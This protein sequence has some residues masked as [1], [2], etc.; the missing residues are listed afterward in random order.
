MLIFFFIIIIL[1][2]LSA[3]FSGSETAFFA[4]SKETHTK[5]RDK[6]AQ[7]TKS[8]KLITRLNLIESLLSNPSSLLATILF[9][10]LVVNT[11]AS[12]VFTLLMITLAEKFNLSRDLLVSLGA[13]ILTIILVTFCEITPKVIA[14]RKPGRFALRTAWFISV[15][16]KIFWFITTPL[17][18]ISDWMLKKISAYV[19][20]APFPSV[21]DLKTIIDVSEDQGLITPEEEDFLFNLVD[22]SNRRVA[23]IM[24]PRIKMICLE[25]EATITDAFSLINK[26]TLPLY[27]R[28]PVYKNSIDNITGV[29]YLKDLVIQKGF[30]SRSSKFLSQPVKDIVRP[31]YF[32]P[33][34]KSLSSLLEE[35]RKKDSHI[36]IVIDEYGQTAGLVTL[37]DILETLLGEIQDEYDTS[38]EM[39]YQIIDTKS[40]LVSGDI[41]LNILD[42]LFEDFSRDIPESAGDRLSGFIYHYWGKIPKK[43]EILIYHNFRI[44]IKDIRRKR[45]NK[46][47]ITKIT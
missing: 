18:R 39:P 19:H 31:A 12:S 14:I 22:L 5:L 1:L 3:V 32:V 23:E 45:I 42:Q 46:V 17:N 25:Q 2:F 34:N 36:A 47:L 29:L 4:F 15:L 11:T 41:D 16:R 40:Y 38:K 6:L 20:K 27:S 21:D 13:I 8:H 43:G 9:S 44:E 37:E 24:T 26:E 33:E 35:L 7:E 28:I 10:N 30:S